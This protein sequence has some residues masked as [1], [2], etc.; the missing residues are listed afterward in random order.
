MCLGS[1]HLG[2]GGDRRW[3]HGLCGGHHVAKRSRQLSYFCQLRSDLSA[4][5]TVDQ[6]WPLCMPVCRETCVRVCVKC[7]GGNG[8]R[9]AYS[10]SMFR[11]SSI[12]SVILAVCTSI[13]IYSTLFTS[14]LLY[15]L[16]FYSILLTGSSQCLSVL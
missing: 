3:S 9:C 12:V 10:R 5:R 6:G 14:I 2:S 16:L 13:Y 7:L 1:E 4:S 8:H 11:H 15:L